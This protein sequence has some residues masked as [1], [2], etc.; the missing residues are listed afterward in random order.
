MIYRK[1]YLSKIEDTIDKPV[2]K[3]ITGIRRSGKSSVMLMLREKLLE[4]NISDKQI[5]HIN[6]ESFNYS[7]LKTAKALYDKILASATEGERMY[8]LFD[9][10]QE[11]DQWEKAINAIMVDF[12]SDIYLTGSNSHLLSS[13]L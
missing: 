7:D 3:I 9:E 10:I 13:N 5:I 4:R 11:V 8:L 6:F 2:I 1:T 12:D